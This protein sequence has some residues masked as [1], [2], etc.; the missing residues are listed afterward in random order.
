M[1][2]Y[3]RKI[4]TYQY[5]KYKKFLKIYGT[6]I[7]MKISIQEIWDYKLQLLDFKLDLSPVRNLQRQMELKQFNGFGTG[8]YWSPLNIITYLK[9]KGF[10]HNQVIKQIQSRNI[11]GKI[12]NNFFK[13]NKYSDTILSVTQIFDFILETFLINEANKKDKIR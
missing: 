4:I 8:Q 12:F 11:D 2:V 6:I 9:D 10:K 13:S 7:S 5:V 3:E 1:Y